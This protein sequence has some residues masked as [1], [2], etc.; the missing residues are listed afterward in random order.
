MQI[1]EVKIRKIFEKGTLRAIVSVSIDGCIAIHDIKIVQGKSRLFVAMPS[2]QDENGNYRDVVH[3]IHSD[4]RK[5]LEADI[6]SVYNN[7]VNVSKIT[8]IMIN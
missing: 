2:R 3:P 1:T 4:E 6:L 8:Q 7:F 5:K